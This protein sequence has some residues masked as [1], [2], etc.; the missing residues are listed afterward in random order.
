MSYFCIDADNMVKPFHIFILVVSLLCFFQQTASADN[1]HAPGL[2]LVNDKLYLDGVKLKDSQRSI[3]FSNI[4]GVDYNYKWQKADNLTSIGDNICM[5]GGISFAG[6]F[7]CGLYSVIGSGMEWSL[8]LF[9][10]DT[11]EDMG[12]DVQSALI[13]GRGLLITAGCF[14]CIGLP[15]KGIGTKKKLDLC[16]LY[17]N[18]ASRYSPE[19]II[20]P[21]NNGVGIRLLF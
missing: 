3:L 15:I 9:L 8:F 13:I 6:A 17:N 18:A 20:G 1:R 2:N 16:D 10:P 21:T 7:F 5:I 14:I 4:D 11:R 19:V 12:K